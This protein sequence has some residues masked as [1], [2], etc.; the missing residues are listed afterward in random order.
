[1][2]AP[3]VRLRGSADAPRLFSGTGAFPA[4][5]RLPLRKEDQPFP[6]SI[7]STVPS[8][9]TI[10]TSGAVWMMYLTL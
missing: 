10:R 1:M 9:R 3:R 4:P 5:E 2:A 8:R 6:P 7:G